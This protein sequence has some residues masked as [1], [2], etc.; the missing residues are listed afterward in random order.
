MHGLYKQSNLPYLAVKLCPNCDEL[1]PVEK[2]ICP[3]CKYNFVY[4]EVKKEETETKAKGNY[5]ELEAYSKKQNIAANKIEEDV[6]IDSL[7]KTNE[8]FVF[9]DNCGAKIIGSQRYCGGCGIKVSKRICQNC[10]Q[11]ID[12]HLTFCPLCGTKGVVEEQVSVNNSP[13]TNVYSNQPINAPVNEEVETQEV[14]QNFEDNNVQQVEYTNDDNVVLQE[15]EEKEKL[16][17]IPLNEVVNMGR[18]RL[19]VIIQILVVAIVAAIMVVMP[20]LT[21]QPF[22]VALVSYFK[23]ENNET[24]ISLSS[25]F[26][27]LKENISS[28]NLIMDEQALESMLT[29]GNNKV[30]FSDV[31]FISLLINA[32]PS[33]L[34]HYSKS[35]SVSL[36]AMISIYGLIILSMVGL[37]ISSIAG[38]FNKSPLK[39]KSLGFVVVTLLVGVVFIYMFNIFFNDFAEYDSWL[40]YGFAITFFIWFIIKIV[41]LKETKKYKDLK[42]YYKNIKRQEKMAK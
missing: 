10:N 28:S 29:N 31:S 30:L 3:N 37:L 24:M 32:F 2:D 8:K 25:L 22:V 23:G 14:N 21:K 7:I 35:L 17:V 39:A 19:F 26:N 41:F 20:I 1:V 15:V 16:E 42:K 11:I 27:Y 18:K 34:E 33:S 5:V 9:C 6:P 40:T 38:L 36:F 4:K 12:A 13:T